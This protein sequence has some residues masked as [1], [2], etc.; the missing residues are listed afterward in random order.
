LDQLAWLVAGH[1]DDVVMFLG[2]AAAEPL[3]HALWLIGS[4]VFFGVLA[5]IGYRR[6]KEQSLS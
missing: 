6:D 3:L 2:Q 4:F 5:I 1:P